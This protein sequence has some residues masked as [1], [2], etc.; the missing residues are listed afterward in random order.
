MADADIS[1]IVTAP[2][3]P[4]FITDPEF[5]WQM[6][7]QAQPSSVTT[8]E[9]TQLLSGGPGFESRSTHNNHQ[10]TVL[11]TVRLERDCV[12]NILFSFFCLV[13]GGNT[14]LKVKMIFV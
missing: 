6:Q 14:F 13:F 8:S 11:S 3:H 1:G 7:K 5:S 12:F 10:T 2:A 4:E 9:V